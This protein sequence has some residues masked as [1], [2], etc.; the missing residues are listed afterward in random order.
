[1]YVVNANGACIPGIGIGT[2]QLLGRSCARIVEEALEIGYRHIDTAQSYENESEVGEALHASG[3]KREEVFLTTKV[4]SIYFALGDLER[5]A[6]ESLVRLRQPYV[7]LLLLHRPN[8]S[9]PLAE[10]L[11]ALAHAK[12]RGLTRHIGVSNF[13]AGLVEEAVKI[14]PE[15][16]VCNQVEYHPYLDQPTLKAACN[17][18][19][20]AVVAYSP[21]AMGK[22]NSDETL[23]QIG[24]LYRKTPAQV[25]LRWLVQQGAVVIPR[26]S[27]PERLAENINILDFQL[28]DAEMDRIYQLGS[29]EGRI[30]RGSF[31]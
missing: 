1:M 9:I 4:N 19:G 21:I 29:P 14:C 15:P 27:R 3:V 30:H 7:D 2:W 8:P 23:Q 22:I 31:V 16:L 13:N 10:T 25:S 18:A 26:T 5:S 24:R 17:Q 20:L 11:G 6:E 28:T 12:R